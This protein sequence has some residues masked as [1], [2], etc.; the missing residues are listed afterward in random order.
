VSSNRP[1]P[2][3]RISRWSTSWRGLGERKRATPAQIALACRVYPKA[4]RRLLTLTFV[5][6]PAG[7]PPGIRVQPAYERMLT[8]PGGAT[9]RRR[10]SE[11]DA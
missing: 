9:Q 11:T 4:A 6:M 10:G 3:R 5:A 1:R 8:G 7:V 2:A